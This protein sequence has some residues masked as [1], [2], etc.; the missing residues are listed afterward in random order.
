MLRYK[1]YA[2]VTK[3]EGNPPA[4]LQ[5]GVFQQPASHS[6]GDLA[7]EQYDPVVM[8]LISQGAKQIKKSGYSYR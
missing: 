8:M 7:P 3:D 4:A 6:G 2:A 1:V 5:M